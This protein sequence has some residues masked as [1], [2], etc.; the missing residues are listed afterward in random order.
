MAGTDPS[1][2]AVTGLTTSEL[3]TLLADFPE[4]E[5][6]MVN[7]RIRHVVTG[8]PALLRRFQDHVTA[9]AEGRGRS[10][11]GKGRRPVGRGIRSGKPCPHRAVPPFGAGSRGGCRG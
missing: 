9:Q 8:A 2:A 5:I 1:M 6:G 7:G 3:E 10:H 4:L 11:A